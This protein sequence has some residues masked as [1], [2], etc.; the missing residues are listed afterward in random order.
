[1]NQAGFSSAL[2]EF[3]FSLWVFFLFGE[4]SCGLLIF[5]HQLEQTWGELCESL[6]HRCFVSYSAWG[7][8]G[9]PSVSSRH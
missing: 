4:L 3:L 1:M 2:V 7:K 9:W 5:C 8:V 6:S